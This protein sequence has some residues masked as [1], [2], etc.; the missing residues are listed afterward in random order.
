MNLRNFL[1]FDRGR[2]GSFTS[3]FRSLTHSAA[4][5]AIDLKRTII[6]CICSETA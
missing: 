6:S 3:G 4:S 1:L 5:G 2:T